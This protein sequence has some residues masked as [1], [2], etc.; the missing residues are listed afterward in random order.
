MQ[1]NLGIGKLPRVNVALRWRVRMGRPTSTVPTHWATLRSGVLSVLMAQIY[2]RRNR[3]RFA[4]DP[5]GAIQGI[6]VSGSLPRKALVPRVHPDP[7]Q[8]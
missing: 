5:L 8:T 1:I 7:L 4:L 6:S 3:A 2:R